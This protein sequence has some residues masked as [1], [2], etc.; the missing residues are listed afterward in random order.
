MK[1]YP[2]LISSDILK[3]GETLSTFDTLCDGYHID[4]MDFHFVPNLTWGPQFVNAFVKAT[5]KPLHV[6]L[7]V[8]NPVAWIDVLD[9]R[10]IDS[11]V[12]H[13]ES[14]GLEQSAKIIEKI[15]QKNWRVGMAINPETAVS[16]TFPF[17][18][19]LD[20]VLLMSVKPGFSGQAFLPGVIDKIG[21]LLEQRDQLGV[22]FSI[23]IDGGVAQDNIRSLSKNGI[24]F[25]CVASAIFSPEDHV[26]ALKDLYATSENERSNL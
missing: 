10:S 26:Q 14:P 22:S 5:S 1:I 16:E 11:F 7:M 12:F 24:D 13:F 20:Q 17:L 3:L 2:S 18:D 21:P 9:L 25:A 6:H 19:L 4:I 8:D 15:K 23:G